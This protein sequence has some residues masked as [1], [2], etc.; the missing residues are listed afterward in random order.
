MYISES[1]TSSNF[2]FYLWLQQSS[3]LFVVLFFRV[4]NL[5][6]ADIMK[7]NLY[8]IS[9][10]S[11]YADL[12]TLLDKSDLRS[13][14]LVD[15][16]GALNKCSI[17]LHSIIES[18]NLLTDASKCHW[19][20]LQAIAKRVETLSVIGYFVGT[21]HCIACSPPPPLPHQCWM[22]F[23]MTFNQASVNI[24]RGWRRGWGF[25]VYYIV[26]WP[27][28]VCHLQRPC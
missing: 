9:Y 4:Y 2:N 7:T 10:H 17:L 1:W 26:H 15:S 18:L 8:Y 23:A 13:Y 28:S 3:G 14:P 24:E 6:V 22:K 5:L 20:M 16:E 27:F 21:H 11:K 25:E 19:S 12:K